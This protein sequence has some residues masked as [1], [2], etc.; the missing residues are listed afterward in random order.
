MID[1][2]P[3]GML[4]LPA[5]RVEPVRDRKAPAQKF[6]E[7]VKADKPLQ[8]AAANQNH[9]TTLA[10]HEAGG[11][12]DTFDEALLRSVESPSATARD[13]PDVEL[14]TARLA[15]TAMWQDLMSLPW[16]L[17]ANA[18]VSWRSGEAAASLLAMA[19]SASSAE[20]YAPTMPGPTT[21]IL[22]GGC[23]H[24]WPRP[25]HHHLPGLYGI[26][27]KGAD[28]ASEVLTTLE[29]VGMAGNVAPF[30]ERMLRWLADEHGTT[31]WVRDYT[32]QEAEIEPLI[33]TTLEHARSHGLPLHRIML[34]GHAIWSAPHST[35]VTE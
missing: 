5:A 22:P 31:A 35:P 30:E 3:P 32:L 4:P 18:G 7:H 2:F 28:P 19:A 6:S 11:R 29:H 26:P 8:S 10:K 12:A 20:S 25:G 9:P 1:R 21:S 17:Q 27:G 16:H 14:P 15:E 34:N 23:V 33:A 13:L 24:Q